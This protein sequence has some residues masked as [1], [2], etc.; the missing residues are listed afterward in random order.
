MHE[1]DLTPELMGELRQE[2]DRL[3]NKKPERLPT[4]PF[5]KHKG[6][7]LFSIPKGY[8]KWM[9]ENC[10]LGTRLEQQIRRYI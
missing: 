10:S 4:M 5:G 2:A 8:L 9:V 7:Y 3:L 1:F 6:E